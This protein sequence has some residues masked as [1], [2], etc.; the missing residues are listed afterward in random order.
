MFTGLVEE[1]GRFLS[2]HASAN[3][4]H[5]LRVQ[6]PRVS[7]EATVGASIAVNGCC[8][9]VTARVGET[10]HFNLLDET[11]RRTN[12]GGLRPGQRVNLEQALAA[13]GRFGGHLVQGHID[14]SAAIRAFEKR[15]ADHRLEIELPSDFARYV[16]AKGSIAIDGTS[17]TVAEVGGENFVAWIIP[18][19]FAETN[20]CSVQA[21]DRVNLEFDLLAKYVE[22]MMAVKT[23]G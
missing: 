19:T 11:L 20:L 7:H 5:E 17:L 10:L 22:R 14:C 23:S 1:T 6:A 8:L 2:R 15:G 18:H 9:T 3:G 16:V 12:L 21:G 4:E 13:S